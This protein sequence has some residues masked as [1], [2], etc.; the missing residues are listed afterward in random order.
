YKA[1]RKAQIDNISISEAI[2]YNR[3]VL[4]QVGRKVEGKCI[5]TTLLTKGLEF[6]T[7]IV[8][9]FQD[10]EDKNNFYVAITRACKKLILVGNTHQIYFK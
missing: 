10:F 3:E 4:R 2:K 6:D 7:V 8:L 1:L 5:G 9:N